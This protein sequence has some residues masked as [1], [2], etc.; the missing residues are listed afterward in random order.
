MLPEAVRPP[1]ASHLDAVRRQH[2]TDLAAGLSRV[3]LPD[4]LARKCPNAPTAWA[5]QFVSPA[6]RICRDA[7]F[8]PPTRFHLHESSIQRPSRRPDEA[9]RMPHVSALLRDSPEA[10]RRPDGAGTPP[11]RGRKHDDDLHAGSE[12]WGLGVTSPLDR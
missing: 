4:A 7:P 3:T 6:G 5:W 9:R 1:L 8:G 12:P 10:V 2:E 11:S